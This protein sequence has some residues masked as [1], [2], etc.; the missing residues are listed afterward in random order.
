[1]SRKTWKGVVALSSL[2]VVCAVVATYASARDNRV[3]T[4]RVEITR[5]IVSKSLHRDIVPGNQACTTSQQDAVDTAWQQLGSIH[6][7]QVLVACVSWN[8]QPVWVVSFEG[9]DVCPPVSG[10]PGNPDAG[11]CIGNTM[12]AR[13]DGV[14]GAWL[15]TFFDGPALTPAEAA[16]ASPAPLTQILQGSSR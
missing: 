8:S 7:A 14:T 2:V 10:P 15:D 11:D 16:S 13:I 12:N 1:M 3:K 5:A 4:S 6:P 9:G